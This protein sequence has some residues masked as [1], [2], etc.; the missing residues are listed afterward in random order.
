[1]KIRR[2]ILYFVLG[3]GVGALPVVIA[4]RMQ[5]LSID[6]FDAEFEV[7]PEYS[8]I[9]N[10]FESGAKVE[11]RSYI[12]I[13]GHKVLHGPSLL[14]CPYAKDAEIKIYNHGSLCSVKSRSIN[15]KTEVGE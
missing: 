8:Y 12:I 14:W 5:I 3:L 13:G 9:S 15:T 11:F 10:H 6:E 4:W 1:M 7:N 2:N